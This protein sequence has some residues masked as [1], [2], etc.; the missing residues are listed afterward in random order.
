MTAEE[1]SSRLHRHDQTVHERLPL[2]EVLSYD[3]APLYRERIVNAFLASE[4]LTVDLSELVNSVKDMPKLDEI[5]LSFIEVLKATLKERVKI[6]F[7]EQKVPDHFFEFIGGYVIDQPSP[8]FDGFVV[9]IV[10]TVTNIREDLLA[11]EVEYYCRD[12]GNSF[13]SMPK[14]R[15]R[16]PRRSCLSTNATV[17]RII[18]ERNEV[19]FTLKNKH[20]TIVCRGDRALLS[21]RDGTLRVSINVEYEVTGVLMRE[22]GKNSRVIYILEVLGIR[23]K[24][25]NIGPAE[26]I[27]DLIELRASFPAIVGEDQAVICSAIAPISRLNKDR[28]FWIMGVVIQGPSSAGKSY[29]MREILRPWQLLGRVK[30]LSRFTGA[31]LE[32]LA[33]VIQRENVDSL[34]ISIP[35]LMSDTPQQLHVLLSEGKLVLGIVDKERGVPIE[36]ELEGQPMLFATTTAI[37]FREDLE[38]RVLIIRI[39]ESFEQTLRVLEY[40]SKLASGTVQNPYS[41]NEY[42]LQRFVS[43]VYSLKPYYVVVPYADVLIEPFK[44]AGTD[45]PVSLRRDF[46][47]MLAIVM[48]SAL[49]FQNDRPKVKANGEE[50]VVA[51][52]KDFETLLTLMKQINITLTRLAPID[53][54]VLCFLDAVDAALNP[55]S[56]TGEPDPALLRDA[57]ERGLINKDAISAVNKIIESY[58]EKA[59]SEKDETKYPTRR[60]ILEF[61]RELGYSVSD[62]TLYRHLTK[63]A[64]LG[65]VQ[66]IESTRPHRYVISRRAFMSLQLI[67]LMQSI[68]ER[69]QSFLSQNGANS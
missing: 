50:A 30:E 12:C 41:V 40:I 44:S 46:T 47:K 63:L 32:R 39:D 33:Q 51:T 5:S 58:V 65:H 56:L 6:E 59:K 48:A 35:E 54:I 25:L 14:S 34:I 11:Q 62:R 29:L 24:I 66:I 20:T 52:E 27:K 3:L 42:S 28:R 38:N 9:S 37:Q 67:D 69:V 45:I 1:T 16:C 13:S 26:R 36:Y 31:Y 49:F 17:T 68:S 61:L 23:Q 18:R 7:P 22:L 53:Y 15:A 57:V 60:D 2:E 4:R 10:G 43:H 55:T 21:N 8:E 64:E 19:R